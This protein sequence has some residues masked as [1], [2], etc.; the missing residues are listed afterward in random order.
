MRVSKGR[1]LRDAMLRIAP[2]HDRM[3]HREE[4]TECASRRAVLRDARFARSSAGQSRK[5]RTE[6]DVRVTGLRD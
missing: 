3:R 5:S 2:Q 4:R 6:Q 1:M